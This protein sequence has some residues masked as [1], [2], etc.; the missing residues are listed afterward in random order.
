MLEGWVSGDAARMVETLSDSDL[1]SGCSQLLRSAIK[2]QK[3]TNYT[4]P[5]RLVH[6]SWY[7]NAHF[8]GTYSYRSMLSDQ[9]DVWASD[10]AEPLEDSYGDIRIL[11]AGEATDTDMYSTVHGAVESGYREAL[12]IA[13]MQ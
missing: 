10:L 6:S 1:L 2:N 8:R 5:V 9:M 13:K 7:T 4:D 11:F 3:M 12:R